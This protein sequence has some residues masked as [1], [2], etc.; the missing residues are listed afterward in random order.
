MAGLRGSSQAMERKPVASADSPAAQLRRFIARFSPDIAALG[1]GTLARMR[2]RLPTAT[3]VVYDNYNAL[4]IGFSPAERAG[5]V[6]FSIVLYPR[7]VSLFFM[8]AMK[9]GLSDPDHLLQGSGNLVRFIPLES[10]AMIDSAPVRR[11]MAQALKGARV[12]LPRTGKGK[13]I[14]KAISA[15]QR[16]R[17]P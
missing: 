16:P 5:G 17:R 14:I 7:R 10:P 8:Q 12:P 6:I 4:G 13:L 1:R 9:S 3:Q 2:K 11:L 15:K